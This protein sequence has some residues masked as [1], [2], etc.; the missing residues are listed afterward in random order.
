MIIFGIVSGM[1]IIIYS[2]YNKCLR[3]RE[4]LSSTDKWPGIYCM[5]GKV[6]I[7][8]FFLFLVDARKLIT[9]FFFQAKTCYI[10]V[11]DFVVKDV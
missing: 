1:S 6:N 11:F 3:L 7:L 8:V 5:L 4:L 2:S 10:R 9:L